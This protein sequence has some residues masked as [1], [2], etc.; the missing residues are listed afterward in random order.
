MRTI[1]IALLITLATQAWAQDAERVSEKL[2]HEVMLN[3]EIINTFNVDKIWVHYH[4]R[5]GKN[6]YNCLVGIV[7]KT[8][9][10][11]YKVNFKSN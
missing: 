5:Y 1:F 4:V 7:S 9:G 3:G 11:C 2:A 10:F 6:F 8:V